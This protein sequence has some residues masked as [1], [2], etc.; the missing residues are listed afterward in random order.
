MSHGRK[1]WMPLVR[2]TSFKWI[3]I[4]SYSRVPGSHILVHLFK[5]LWGYDTYVRRTDQR[6]TEMNAS[7]KW[8][9]LYQCL[10]F[11]YF[12]FYFF[13][14]WGCKKFTEGQKTWMRYFHA[15]SVRM[16]HIR[17]TSLTVKHPEHSHV[18]SVQGKYGPSEASWMNFNKVNVDK[19]A[20]LSG[21]YMNRNRRDPYMQH[22]H[23]QPH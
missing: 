9:L 11:F 21:I 20:L 12:I 5:V 7:C 17:R 1:T 19:E 15:S 16:Y 4:S 13:L 22:M 23:V 8:C 3:I 6:R 14:G 10:L 18:L 2:N